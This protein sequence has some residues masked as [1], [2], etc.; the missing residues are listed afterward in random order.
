MLTG[1]PALA[2]CVA[3]S[4]RVFAEDHWGRAPRLSRAAELPAGFTDLI[5]AV[6]ADELVSERGLRTPFLRMAKDGAV[7]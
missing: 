5:D 2:R 4:A 6:A 7:R 3:C 1:G